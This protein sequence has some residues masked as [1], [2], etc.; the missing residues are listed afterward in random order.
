MTS[1]GGPPGLPEVTFLVEAT[2]CG[3]GQRKVIPEFFT[4]QKFGN[5]FSS[6]R[7]VAVAAA[8]NYVESNMLS[9]S[10]ILGTPHHRLR[11]EESGLMSL[12]SINYPPHFV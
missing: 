11:V 1:C 5:D 4:L 9:I 10:E 8:R 12:T 2:L 7:D 3:G 6:V